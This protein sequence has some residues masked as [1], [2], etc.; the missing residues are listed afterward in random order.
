LSDAEI[1]RLQQTAGR[2]V[3]NFKRF[4]RDLRRQD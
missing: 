1:E 3:E 4:K 2:Y